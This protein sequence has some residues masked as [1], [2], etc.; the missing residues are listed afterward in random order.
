MTAEPPDPPLDALA[1]A[2]AALRASGD[3]AVDPAPTRA[4]V[5]GTLR[6]RRRARLVAARTLIPIAAVLA[7]SLAWA[8]PGGW[9]AAWRALSGAPSEPA[10]AEAPEPVGAVL[11]AP[12]APSAAAAS[13][14]EPEER[15]A[16]SAPAKAV[17]AP[18]R[19]SPERAP[20]APPP[21]ASVSAAAEPPDHAIYKRAHALHF[22]GGDPGAALRAWDEYLRAAPRGRFAMEAQYNRAIC[23]ARLG[24]AADAARALEPFANGSAGGYRQREAKALQDALGASR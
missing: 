4:R 16:P 8:G 9:S 23:L 7:G 10:P 14:A 17:R 19:P 15:P 18:P 13:G 12:P 1:S 2:A 3:A 11:A 21:S 24:R 6:A 20:P 22:S 5:L